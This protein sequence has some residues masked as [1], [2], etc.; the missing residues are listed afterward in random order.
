M[1]STR[2]KEMAKEPRWPGRPD[3]ARAAPVRVTEAKRRRREGVDPLLEA[4]AREHLLVQHLALARAV[5]SGST[6][7]AS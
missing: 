7:A 3:A 2:H 1:A 4:Q 5:I 6:K